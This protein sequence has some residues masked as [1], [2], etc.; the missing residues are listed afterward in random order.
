MEIKILLE[1]GQIEETTSMFE[2]RIGDESEIDRD[3]RWLHSISMNDSTDSSS[4]KWR[5]SLRKSDDDGDVDG[6]D[7]N[8]NV[9]RKKH[10]YRHQTHSVDL[11]MPMFVETTTSMEPTESIRISTTI[12][13]IEDKRPLLSDH[14]QNAPQQCDD[15]DPM[16]Q[17]TNTVNDEDDDDHPVVKSLPNIGC[18][19]FKIFIVLTIFFSLIIVLLYLLK[20][21]H[22]VILLRKHQSQHHHTHPNLTIVAQ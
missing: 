20:H 11:M 18:L 21:E 2:D 3:F 9:R 22:D 14:N 8:H 7:I 19:I 1:P 13:S 15:C 17:N 4:F 5:S 6:R 12:D 10:R 16:H